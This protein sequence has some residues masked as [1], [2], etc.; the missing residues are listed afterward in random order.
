MEW[1]DRLRQVLDRTDIIE[2][3]HAYAR[4]ADAGD[5]DRMV[6]RFIEDCTAEYEPG[7][8]VIEGRQALR[9]WYAYRLGN[10]VASSHHLSNFE[11]AFPD[12][13]TALVRCYLYSWQRLRGFPATADRHRWGR[14][15]DTWVRTEQGWFQSSLTYL[16]AGE[17]S[18]D[19]V[20]RV[21][22]YFERYD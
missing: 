17:L 4:A 15:V 5:A 1:S 3:K 13:D 22:E 10:V 21:G 12:P 16:L 8:P 14:Y 18:G 11:V 9:D 19:P 6:Q 2:L 7:A 20:P